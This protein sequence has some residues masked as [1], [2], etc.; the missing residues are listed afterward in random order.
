MIEDE[1]SEQVIGL[2]CAMMLGFVVGIIITA[3]IFA[4]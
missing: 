4:V 2:G 1:R 3:V